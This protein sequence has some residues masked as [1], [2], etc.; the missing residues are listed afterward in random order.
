MPV[1]LGTSGKVAFTTMR[2]AL[3]Q[4]AVRGVHA[5]RR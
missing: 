2:G 1:M 5:Y 3:P 4:L